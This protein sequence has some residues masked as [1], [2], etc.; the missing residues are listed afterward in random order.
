MSSTTTNTSFVGDRVNLRS[1]MCS[2]PHKAWLSYSGEATLEG[3]ALRLNAKENGEVFADFPGRGET[4]QFH[5]AVLANVGSTT[6]QV[7]C[8]T[9]GECL[10][11]LDGGFKVWTESNETDLWKALRTFAR[12]RKRSLTNSD[13]DMVS[14]AIAVVG[15]PGYLVVGEDKWNAVSSI[16]A[17]ICRSFNAL[18]TK[19]HEFHVA[20]LNRRPECG[21]K[22]PN[23]DWGSAYASLPLEV[24]V[25]AWPQG[26]RRE[27]LDGVIV[28]LG[29]GYSRAYKPTGEKIQAW[30]T[31][32]RPN[33]KT[34]EF[35]FDGKQF[36][37]E[38]LG[39]L[40]GIY[41]EALNNLAEAHPELT[42]DKGVL[43]AHI[44][45][46]GKAR[47]AMLK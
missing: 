22:Q 42:D 6:T 3:L 39:K 15:A 25:P 26:P 20:V 10:A 12:L 17:P 35:L 1:S 16:D 43:N 37:P 11:M 23:C 45:G 36:H 38:R 31:E 30:T 18:E 2:E 4:N 40:E 5:K 47:E 27:H 46:T 29:G 41:K 8:V 9:T 24:V 13:R 7:Y 19:Y 34:N 28:D 44:I 33:I 14:T 21:F 32:F